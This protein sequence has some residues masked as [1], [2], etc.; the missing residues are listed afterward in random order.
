MHEDAKSVPA[1][2]R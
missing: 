1:Y 2:L